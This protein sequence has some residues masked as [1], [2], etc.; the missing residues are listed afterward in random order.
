MLLC[1]Q[2]LFSL[3]YWWNIINTNEK[4]HIDKITKIA[5]S[6][7]NVSLETRDENFLIKMNKLNL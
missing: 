5:I 6:F 3:F 4:L 2:S 1:N 7:E